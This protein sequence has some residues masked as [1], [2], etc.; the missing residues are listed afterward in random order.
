MTRYIYY[1]IAGNSRMVQIFAVFADRA[2]AAK[3]RTAKLWTVHVRIVRMRSDRAKIK[4]TKIRDQTGKPAE[5]P[6]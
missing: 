1:R 3:I 2:A 6:R 4:T 5:S